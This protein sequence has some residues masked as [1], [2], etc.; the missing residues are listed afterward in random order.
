MARLREVDPDLVR[1]AGL[2]FE[3]HQR[4]VRRVGG[5]AA[6]RALEVL[7]VDADPCSG[8]IDLIVGADDVPGARW[9]DLATA[10]G[11]LDPESLRLALPRAADV[12][13]LAV[14][15]EAEVAVPE[16]L[17]SVL[18]SARLG[19]DVVVVDLPRSGFPRDQVLPLCDD[20]LLVVTSDVR[21]ST[22]GR[23][24]LRSLRHLPVRLAVRRV[25]HGVLDADEVA[26]WCETDLAVEI[27]DEP[28]IMRTL[29]RG[30][31]PVSARSRW[32]KVH[33]ELAETVAP[34]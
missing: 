18:D 11:F 33:R 15:R 1:A 29:E 23:R 28:R 3:F 32:A 5:P 16:S 9:S 13:V 27:P 20:V 7:L 12:D 19:Y 30:G 8:G 21:G 24:V 22:T 26:A 4:E 34:S 10:S 6:A 25:R 14:D 17:C 2:E 31:G